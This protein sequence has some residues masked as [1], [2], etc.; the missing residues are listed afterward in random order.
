MNLYSWRK[1]GR[2][3]RCGPAGKVA[4]ERS[5]RFLT[6][7]RCLCQSV[8]LRDSERSKNCGF[9]FVVLLDV[10]CPQI[11]LVV[12]NQGKQ[13]FAFLTP[14]P[15]DIERLLPRLSGGQ[16]ATAESQWRHRRLE[17]FLSTLHQTGFELTRT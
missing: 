7:M 5:M 15:V 17:I 2:A 14:N 11:G 16:V 13:R 9:S 1:E 10:A 6:R 8:A 4:S 12:I 3:T